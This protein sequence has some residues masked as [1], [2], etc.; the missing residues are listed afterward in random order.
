MF[1]IQYA[2][3]EHKSNCLKVFYTVPLLVFQVSLGIMFEYIYLFHHTPRSFREYSCLCGICDRI[4]EISEKKKGLRSL[5]SS[6]MDS[7]P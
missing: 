4:R 7:S 1:I 5:K 3:Y 2:R 6:V